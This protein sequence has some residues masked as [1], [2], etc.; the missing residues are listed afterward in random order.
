MTVHDILQIWSQR[1]WLKGPRSQ[2]DVKPQK[3]DAGGRQSEQSLNHLKPKPSPVQRA[4]GSEHQASD[5]TAT[6]G[7]ARDDPQTSQI[8]VCEESSIIDIAFFFFFFFF[9]FAPVWILPLEIRV[10]F[11]GKAN[12]T[13]SRYLASSFITLVD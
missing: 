3:K 5:S 9:L 13:K 11:A 7:R 1:E 8:L 6:N 10:A 12:L 4:V 2:K